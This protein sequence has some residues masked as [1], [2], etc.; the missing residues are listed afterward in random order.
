MMPVENIRNLDQVVL[1][2]LLFARSLHAGL[3]SG[4]SGGT[5]EAMAGPGAFERSCPFL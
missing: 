5:K 1:A 4:Q 2:T 3:Q